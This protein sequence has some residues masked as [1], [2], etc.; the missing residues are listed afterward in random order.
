MSGM[1]YVDDDHVMYEVRAAVSRPPHELRINFSTGEVEPKNANS[2]RLLKSVAQHREGLDDFL[3]RNNV[4][5]SSVNDVTLYHRLTKRGGETIM[6]ARDD[7]G[8]E[9]IITVRETL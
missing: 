4:N 9:H 3:T 6:S 1:N 7:R 5:P 8:V 2:P